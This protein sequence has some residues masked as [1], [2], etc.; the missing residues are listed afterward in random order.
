MAP[1]ARQAFQSREIRATLQGPA[2]VSNFR[3]TPMSMDHLACYTPADLAG[4][5]PPDLDDHVAVGADPPV[6]DSVGGEQVS[7]AKEGHRPSSTS[8]AALAQEREEP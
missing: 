1:V 6:D 4:R 2:P 5:S 3:L 8:D 7:C